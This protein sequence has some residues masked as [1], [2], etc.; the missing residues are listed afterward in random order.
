M[1]AGA[2]AIAGLPDGSS[3]V[4]AI[5]NDGNAYHDIRF[6]SGSWSGFSAVQGPYG[7]STFP[8]QRVGIAG[9]PDGSSQIL[10]VRR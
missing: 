8:S 2:V 6:A 4:L 1:S 10:D 9:M 7:S 3:Q 5:G